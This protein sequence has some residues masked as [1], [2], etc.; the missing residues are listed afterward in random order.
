[1]VRFI[2][3]WYALYIDFFLIYLGT[4]ELL[5]KIPRLRR[6]NSSVPK[7]VSCC[8]WSFAPR[9]YYKNTCVSYNSFC[10]CVGVCCQENYNTTFVLIAY[11][12]GVLCGVLANNGVASFHIWYC[13]LNMKLYRHEPQANSCSYSVIV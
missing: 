11:F 8:L 9:K 5:Q 6:A 13:R 7:C 12:C 3:L 4:Y 2:M 10:D 1:M